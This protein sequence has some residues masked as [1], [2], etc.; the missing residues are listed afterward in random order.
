MSQSTIK[1]QS[2]LNA[3]FCDPSQMFSE[4][5]HAMTR[6]ALHGLLEHIHKIAAGSPRDELQLVFVALTR[7]DPRISKDIPKSSQKQLAEMIAEVDRLEKSENFA[8]RYSIT[9]VL[10]R[11]SDNFQ[12]WVDKGAS[13]VWCEH[14]N[15]GREYPIW[16][17]FCM[18]NLSAR[19]KAENRTFKMS[20]TPKFAQSIYTFGQMVRPDRKLASTGVPVIPAAKPVLL[21]FQRKQTRE[22]QQPWMGVD[23]ETALLD[24]RNLSTLGRG[25]RLDERRSSQD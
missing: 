4:K 21:V 8:I 5:V 7:D 20:F 6:P 2:V 17:D 3:K 9:A 15:D 16:E 19:G 14:F 12:E 13:G 11:D 25:E 18:S 10:T 1:I 23:H 22:S 24:A